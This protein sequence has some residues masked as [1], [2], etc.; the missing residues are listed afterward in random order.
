MLPMR[1]VECATRFLHLRPVHGS[2]SN[3]CVRFC[4][5]QRYPG[6]PR[7]HAVASTCIFGDRPRSGPERT[8]M[9]KHSVVT[10]Q[11]N[12]LPP[13]KI[14]RS[15]ANAAEARAPCSWP[16]PVP[17]RSTIPLSS[18]V[19]D[20]WLTINKYPNAT[21]PGTNGTGSSLNNA[22]SPPFYPSPYVNLF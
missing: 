13:K 15:R 11:N 17:P 3:P 19:Y 12:P 21:N 10:L 16:L 2:L 1:R 22:Q 7:H 9:C 8:G 5:Q 18:F 20:P 4:C 6:S 14:Y